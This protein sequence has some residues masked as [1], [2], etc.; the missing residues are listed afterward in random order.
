MGLPLMK[1]QHFDRV[2]RQALASLP[3]QFQQL[4]E[5]VI[6]SVQQYADQELLDEMEADELLGLYVGTPLTERHFDD[7]FMLPD[8]ILLFQGALEDACQDEQELEEEIRVTLIHEVGHFF[9]L[10]E[11]EIEEALEAP[12]R[13]RKQAAE[14]ADPSNLQEDGKG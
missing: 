14:G 13:A 7:T 4:M 2:V 11:E 8:Q 12:H 9:G 6:I 1:V 3:E 10:S 5:N